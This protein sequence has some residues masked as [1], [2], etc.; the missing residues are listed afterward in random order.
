MLKLIHNTIFLVNIQILQY[1][2]NLK[3]QRNHDL[4]Q[5]CSTLSSFV[6]GRNNG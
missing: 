6:E 5:C 3:M 4:I 1:V 2:T